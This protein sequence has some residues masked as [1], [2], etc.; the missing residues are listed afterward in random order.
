MLLTTLF[1]AALLVGTVRAGPTNDT[2][3]TGVSSEYNETSQ[4]PKHT[5]GA[6]CN[7]HLHEDALSVL[8]TYDHQVTM[9][10]FDGNESHSRKYLSNIL[11]GTITQISLSIL[12]ASPP[13]W[14]WAGTAVR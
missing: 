8:I 4:H 9:E 3:T 5:V 7:F 11:T 12:T 14:R 6:R 1:S 10:F 2:P 13:S